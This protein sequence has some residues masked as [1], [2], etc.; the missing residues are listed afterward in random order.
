MTESTSRWSSVGLILIFFFFSENHIYSREMMKSKTEH[1]LGV[2]R[3]P[4]N[5][6]IIQFTTVKQLAVRKMKS[7]SNFR[8][9]RCFWQCKRVIHSWTWLRLDWDLVF[10]AIFRSVICVREF[11]LHFWNWCAIFAGSDFRLLL[12]SDTFPVMCSSVDCTEF[13]LCDARTHC[14]CVCVCVLWCIISTWET[15]KQRT[16]V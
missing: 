2:Q 10:L 8:T 16:S 1:L 11:W 13:K 9:A 5:F 6:I 3:Y 12:S 4:F 7:K 14:V 15:T